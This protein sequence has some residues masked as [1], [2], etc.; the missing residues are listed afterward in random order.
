[1]SNLDCLFADPKKVDIFRYD[2]PILG[3]RRLPTLEWEFGKTRIMDTDRFSIDM[4][5]NTVNLIQ[6]GSK[7]DIGY[8]LVY[9]V[10]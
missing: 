9:I 3:P 10:S 8:Q 1:M 7:Q 4:I 5:S 6:N 2:D